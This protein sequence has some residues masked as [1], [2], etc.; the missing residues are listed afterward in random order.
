VKNKNLMC[1]VTAVGRLA[2]KYP[3]RFVYTLIGIDGD[4]RTRL[5]HYIK[6]EKL[7]DTVH[8]LGF[9]DN[10]RNYLRAFD[11]FVLPSL[12]EGMPYG[13]LE[14]GAA[15]LP[16]IASNVGGI[17]E[18]ITHNHD[19]LL[20][21]PRNSEELEHALEAYLENPDIYKNFGT[22]LQTKIQTSFNVDNMITD[23]Q[24]LY[25]VTTQ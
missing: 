3:G 1:A 5:E 16:C 15:G 10:A 4:E 12:K 2:Q 22:A 19:G 13:L 11:I 7:E 9:V 21:D 14:A 17:P 24:R 8:L 23:T 18:I 6:K 20:I 25:G